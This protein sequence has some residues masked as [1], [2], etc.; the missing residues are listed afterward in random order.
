[1]N[2]TRTLVANSRVDQELPYDMTALGSQLKLQNWCTSTCSSDLTVQ[3]QVS[4]LYATDSWMLGLAKGNSYYTV[5]NRSGTPPVATTGDYQLAWYTWFPFLENTIGSFGGGNI[6]VKAGGSISLVQFVSPT[7]ARDAGPALVATSY[8]P[9]TQTGLYVQGGGNISVTAGGNISGVYT[10]VQ[11]GATS[12]K[13]G[14]SV[15]SM[16]VFDSGAGAN[17]HDP[18]CDRDLDRRRL[19]SGRPQHRHRRP[20]R[21][22]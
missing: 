9:A 17:R 15:G 16:G 12:L 3:G 6:S 14:G 21:S 4:A 5:N 11:N 7:N 1:M 2:T 20:D 13:A 19:G 18:N 10:Y 8:N 22:A